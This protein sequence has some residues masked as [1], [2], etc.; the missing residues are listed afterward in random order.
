[1]AWQECELAQYW[2][3]QDV[4][5]RQG[6]RAG[7]RR[8]FVHVYFWKSRRYEIRRLQADVSDDARVDDSGMSVTGRCV[9]FV[10][11][12]QRTQFDAIAL[13]AA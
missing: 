9:E 4:H 1:M 12:A 10:C 5:G 6:G 2:L 3:Q 8:S 13:H 11:A 7:I